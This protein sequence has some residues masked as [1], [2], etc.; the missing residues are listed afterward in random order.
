MCGGE[1]QRAPGH[2]PFRR[3]FWGFMKEVVS[4][5]SLKEIHQFVIHQKPIGAKLEVNPSL[6]P[7]LQLCAVFPHFHLE[8][9]I[10]ILSSITLFLLRPVPVTQTSPLVLYT[11]YFIKEDHLLRVHL[12]IKYVFVNNVTRDP[13][14]PAFWNSSVSWSWLYR[15]YSTVLPANNDSRSLAS[16][17]LIRL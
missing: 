13:I 16:W 8:P 12:R 14:L 3:Q 17:G 6:L 15:N 5:L 10:Q 2:S 7:P 4:E 1:L 9:Q 11:R